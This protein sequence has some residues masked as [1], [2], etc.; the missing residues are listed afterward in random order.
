MKYLTNARSIVP[1]FT[2]RALILLALLVTPFTGAF[3]Q[4][5]T[6]GALTG[7]VTDTQ[8]RP[9]PGASVLA[10]HEPSGTTY[11]GTTRADGRFQIPGMRV[12]G[13]YTVTVNFVGTGTTFE[14]QTVQDITINLGAAQDVNFTVKS[15][16]VQE[17][18]TVTATIDPVF[19][20]GRTGAS[21]TV[22]RE[23]IALVPTLGG[24]I[25][26]VLRLTPQGS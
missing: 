21:T 11:E 7:V 14:P 8:M 22:S 18:V 17:N 15:I 5:V 23:E 2:R 6:T 20:S 10:I 12:G 24:R 1:C 13:P 3:A 16:A 19:S 9:V 25:N 4:G 26:D